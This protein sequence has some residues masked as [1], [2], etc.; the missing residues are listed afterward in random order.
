MNVRYTR[1]IKD[2]V[3][4]ILSSYIRRT[5]PTAG[6]S[7]VSDVGGRECMTGPH[8]DQQSPCA[9]GMTSKG[10]KARRRLLKDRFPGW[11]ES[12]RYLA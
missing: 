2:E 10:D 4:G 5:A 12:M 3:E 1:S 6:K 9:V 7:V 8:G 11:L